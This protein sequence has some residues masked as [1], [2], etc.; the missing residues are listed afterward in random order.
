MISVWIAFGAALV[1]AL[2]NLRV[3]MVERSGEAWT[4]PAALSVL[5]FVFSAVAGATE[6]WTGFWVDHTR[7]LWGNQIWMDLLF[8]ASVGW[9]LLV[10]RARAAGM[11]TVPWLIAVAATGSIGLLAM[12]AR[13]LWLEAA[14]RR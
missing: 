7:D 13:L 2:F 1:A 14:E 5:F 6:G 11:P 3:A 10:P 9:W 12:V 8:S 4:L